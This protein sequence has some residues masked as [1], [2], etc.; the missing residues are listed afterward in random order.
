M[1]CFGSCTGQVFFFVVE[2]VPG[3]FFRTCESDGKCLP[4]IPSM[5]M[6]ICMVYWLFFYGKC[7]VNIADIDPMGWAK[8][9][10]NFTNKHLDET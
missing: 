6:D 7:I 9:R 4:V 10:L 2:I 1:L 3:V 5:F 8:V